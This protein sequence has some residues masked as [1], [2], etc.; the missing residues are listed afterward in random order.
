MA[1]G[2]PLAGAIGRASVHLLPWRAKAV[3]RHQRRVR[4]TASRREIKAA[5]SEAFA[6]YTRYWYEMFRLPHD[7]KKPLTRF[8]SDGYEYIK[9]AVA[10]GRGAIMAIPHIGGW[11]YAGAWLA[12]QGGAA[13]VAV[14][15]AVEP[16][17]L[18]ALFR[19]QRRAMGMEIIA[20]GPDSGTQVA[21]ALHDNRV[22]CLLSDRDI[23]G[24]GIE[25]EFFGER[26]TL[27]AGP[28][29]LSI[30]TGAPLLPVAVY[31]DGR[32]NFA[33]VLP[34][35]DTSR[36]GSLRAD[37]ARI[38]QDMAHA[39]EQLIRAAPEQWHMMQP[40]WPSDVSGASHESTTRR[41]ER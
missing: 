25:V 8:S 22:L 38:T 6:S 39:L 21:K 16:P 13:P 5:T 1:I 26:T 33:R 27:P 32:S 31:F 18:F 11:E 7:A 30:R 2:L 10:D 20:L 35:L 12:Q 9:Q 14:V 17:E 15:E 28:A 37:V 19:D 29:L 23:S 4:P 41:A 36:Q 40:N 3:Y 34:P 24:D